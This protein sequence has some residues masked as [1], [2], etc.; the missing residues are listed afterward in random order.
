[1][2][3][4][5]RLFGA[6]TPGICRHGSAWCGSTYSRCPGEPS[7]RP[8]TSIPFCSTRLAPITLGNRQATEFKPVRG[9]TEQELAD[10]AQLASLSDETSRGPLDRR[11]REGK[12]RDPRARAREFKANFIPFTAQ[13]RM[14]GVEVGNSWVRKGAVDSILNFLSPSPVSVGTSAVRI[15]SAVSS[16]V[17]REVNGD[18]RDDLK[19]WRHVRWPLP[20][21]DG[22]SAS[23]T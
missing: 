23:F 19:G 17:A 15:Q 3:C 11:A 7:R 20:K 6:G 10:A 1:M 14:S 4:V 13:S 12:V 21:T 16:D 2:V 5:L 8:A 18:R 9:V 22:C